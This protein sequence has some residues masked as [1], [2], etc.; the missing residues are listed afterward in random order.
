[1]SMHMEVFV[2]RTATISRR[3]RP[4]ARRVKTRLQVERLEDRLTPSTTW[5]EQG[6]G[7]ILGG[8]TQGIPG[9]PV[10]GAIEAIAVGPTNADVVYAG[11]VN[12]GVWK[13]T[14]A[15]AA[16][17]AWTPLTDLQLPEISIDS[18]AI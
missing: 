12:G 2:M 4:Q 16:D 10:A 7:P 5:V 15:T 9:N 13:T 17:P 3:P 18:L 11:S 8:S 6:P 1:M 14:N